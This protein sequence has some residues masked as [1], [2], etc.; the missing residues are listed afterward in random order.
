MIGWTLGSCK[1]FILFPFSFSTIQW[2]SPNHLNIW[3]PWVLYKIG[4]VT[5]ELKYTLFPFDSMINLISP[6]DSKSPNFANGINEIG[7]RVATIIISCKYLFPMSMYYTCIFRYMLFRVVFPFLFVNRF[8]I[9]TCV[10]MVW[11]IKFIVKLIQIIQMNAN[12]KVG[13]LWLPN[14]F[15]K[16]YLSFGLKLQG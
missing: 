14:T 11:L 10:L 4:V 15:L 7:S 3:N 13:R 5:L 8:G 16:L 6:K 9:T 12:R 2:L 1:L